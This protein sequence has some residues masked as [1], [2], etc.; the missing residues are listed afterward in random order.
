MNTTLPLIDIFERTSIVF[1]LNEVIDEP[2]TVIFNIA[3]IH[4]SSH[5]QFNLA[6]FEDDAHKLEHMLSFE[7]GAY[8][9]IE[10]DMYITIYHEK[11]LTLDLSIHLD[12]ELINHQP[13]INHY[14]S[15]DMTVDKQ[16]FTKLVNYLFHHIVPQ[17]NE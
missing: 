7:A 12:L 4:D 17:K 14:E 3:F 2:R 16:S 5:Q 8:H 10:S 1:K 9:F 15:F 6:F 13:S 11:A